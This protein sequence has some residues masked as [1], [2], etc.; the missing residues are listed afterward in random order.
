MKVSQ[1][2]GIEPIDHRRVAR[3]F[4]ISRTKADVFA[5][6]YLDRIRCVQDFTVDAVR[7]SVE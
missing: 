6:P 3:R 5:G 4:P 1:R 7:R 2:Y